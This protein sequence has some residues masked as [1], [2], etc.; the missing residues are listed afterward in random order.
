[1][2]VSDALALQADDIGKHL[3]ITGADDVDISIRY[4]GKV[5]WVNTALG[6]KL[7]IC[8]IRGDVNISDARKGK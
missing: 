8:S 6:C 4:D 7:R 3:D 5:I 1:M 2:K